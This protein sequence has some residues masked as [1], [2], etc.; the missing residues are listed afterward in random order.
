MSKKLTQVDRAIQ[1]LEDE[2]LICQRAIGVLQ[3]QRAAAPKRKPRI[4]LAKPAAGA[5]DAQ[6][7]V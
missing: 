3:Q 6:G 7:N 2:I 5:R 1:Q 4:A